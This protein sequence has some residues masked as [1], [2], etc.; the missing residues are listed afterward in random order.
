MYELLFLASVLLQGT[1]G[2]T[3]QQAVS[4]IAHAC[5]TGKA[6][7]PVLVTVLTM[8]SVSCRARL[9]R[10]GGSSNKKYKGV[11][12]W[13][14]LRDT[15]AFAQD[16]VLALSVRQRLMH[17]MWQN[18]QCLD[19]GTVPTQSSLLHLETVFTSSASAAHSSLLSVLSPLSSLL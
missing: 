9:T 7:A 19:T 10:G 17:S 8:G 4:H 16:L 11:F 2:L 18:R 3:A 6:G 13:S 1:K 14:P 5:L 12:S 15:C